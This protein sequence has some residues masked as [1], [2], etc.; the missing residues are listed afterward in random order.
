MLGREKFDGLPD[1]QRRSILGVLMLA[2]ATDEEML[3]PVPNY[4][5]RI[6][7]MKAACRPGLYTYSMSRKNFSKSALEA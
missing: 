7:L 5:D 2:P 4:S 3:E 1:I 6:S